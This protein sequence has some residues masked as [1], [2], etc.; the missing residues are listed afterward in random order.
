[1]SE[2]INIICVI[3]QPTNT[4]TNPNLLVLC[5]SFEIMIYLLTLFP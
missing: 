1:M 3:H 4:H 5:V 2:Y